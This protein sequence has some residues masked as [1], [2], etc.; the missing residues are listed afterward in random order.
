VENKVKAVVLF[1]GGLDS[2]TA[3]AIS[4][5]QNFQPIALTINYQQRHKY[6]IQASKRI[7]NDYKDI[8]H[9]IFD[10]DLTRIG[11]SALTDHD[12]DIPS[13]RSDD[14]PVTYVPARNT[15]F[16][17]IA[18]A[19]AEKLDISDIFMGVN[20]IDYSGYP[21]CRPE[22]IKSF[23]NTINLATKTGIEGKGIRIHTPLIDLKKSEIIQK[24]L[25]LGVDY[26]KTISCYNPSD[27]GD[28]CGKCD[29]CHYR[30]EGF[31]EAGVTD[32]TRYKK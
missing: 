22:F 21:D 15:I 23:E 26:S 14:I 29:S 8:D 11:G 18:S 19:Y 7:L 4:Q 5:S 32:P 10:L 31:N 16:L 9:F 24:G 28:A 1:S 13:K 25:S 17:S 6:E 2:T 20:A 12:I 3:L 27:D 30:K